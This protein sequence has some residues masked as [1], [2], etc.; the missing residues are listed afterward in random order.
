MYVYNIW[1]YDD[2]YT[3]EKRVVLGKGLGWHYTLILAQ[4]QVKRLF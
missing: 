1:K 3:I 2:A 4:Q